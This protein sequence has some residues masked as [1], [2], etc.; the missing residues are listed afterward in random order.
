MLD[1]KRFWKSSDFLKP[2]PS[3]FEIEKPPSG[4]QHPLS[5]NCGVWVCRR[6]MQSW[7]YRDYILETRTCLAVDLVRGRHNLIGPAI[8]HKAIAEWDWAMLEATG[9]PNGLEDDGD[10]NESPGASVTL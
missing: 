10:G 1:D 3:A 2:S 7:I 4:Q 6:M 8:R 9:G 5:N